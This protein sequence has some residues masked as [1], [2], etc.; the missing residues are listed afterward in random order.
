M[1]KYKRLCNLS[2][3]SIRRRF[4]Q[5]DNPLPSTSHFVPHSTIDPLSLNENESNMNCDSSDCENVSENEYTSESDDEAEAQVDVE[6]FLIQWKHSCNVSSHALSLLLVY[7]KATAFP[8]LPKDARTLL[9]TPQNR[10]VVDI[11]PGK[12][13]HMGLKKGLDTIMAKHPENITEVILDFNIDGL[14]ISRS[15]TSGFWLI[16]ARIHNLLPTNVFVVGIYHGT[17]KPDNFADFL[18]P[19]V[20]ELKCMMENYTYEG[21]NIKIQI[22]SYICDAP[23]RAAVTGTKGHNARFGCSKCCQEG[24]FLKN[25]MTF[26]EC[27]VRLRC[28]DS[29]RAKID[30]SYHK[31]RSPIEDLQI[32]MVDGFPLDYL[33][34]VC[35]GVV[36]K[37]FRMWIS[38]DTS[39][40]MPSNIINLIS[41]RLN[42][43]S[44]TQPSCFQRKIRPLSEFGYF[45]G[46]ELRTLIL[47]AGPFALKDALPADMYENFKLL[48]VAITLLCDKNKCLA[49]A[50]V[51]QAIIERFVNEFA[52]IYGD[53][54][55]IYNMHS[56]THLVND[57]LKHGS[58]DNYSAFAFESYMYQIKRMIHKN[59]QPLA[60]ICNR[61]A[62]MQI[63]G[64]VNLQSM[65]CNNPTLKK[66][67]IVDSNV[68]F[69]EILLG[70]LKFNNTIKDQWFLTYEKEIVCMQYAQKVGEDIFIYGDEIRK[71]KDFYTTPIASSHLDIFLTDGI[72]AGSPKLFNIKCIDKKLFAMQDLNKMVFFPLLHNV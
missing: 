34:V 2:R 7:L 19:H 47:Y 36:K 1:Y 37:M 49:Y 4:S 41:T 3:R 16:L 23:A 27:S 12:Y 48:H 40:L 44:E 10:E 20:D 25:R 70:D 64:Y 31:Y 53:H 22:R 50:E 6:T 63:A 43:I 51:A 59:S 66:K 56:L 26:P 9:H 30:E 72:Q 13:V 65:S 46:T 29:F 52:E 62:E 35:L 67:K 45:K 32:D 24:V 61:L 68:V 17:H 39:S 54:H 71:K 57:T 42:S 58:L 60:Q 21:R 38:G 55:I 18:Q 14:P 69:N 33:H 11:A 15:S 5:M 8:N 28:N